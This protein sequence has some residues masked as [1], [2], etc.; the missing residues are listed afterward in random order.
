MAKPTIS[1]QEIIH[2]MKLRVQELMSLLTPEQRQLVIAR[3]QARLM[4]HLL[5]R[6]HKTIGTP[7]PEQDPEEAGVGILVEGQ[8]DEKDIEEKM[9][10]R[11]LAKSRLISIP[12][13]SK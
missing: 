3:R 10:K 9:A 5:G 11:E 12:K 6:A 7:A 4:P 2:N 1:N 8:M 13:E